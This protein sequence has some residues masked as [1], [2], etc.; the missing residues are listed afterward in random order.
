MK[1]GLKMLIKKPFIYRGTCLRG[2]EVTVI[3]EQ[4]NSHGEWACKIRLM[5]RPGIANDIWI[6]DRELLVPSGKLAKAIFI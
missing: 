2:M 4:I 5:Q 3:K 1:N 6:Y